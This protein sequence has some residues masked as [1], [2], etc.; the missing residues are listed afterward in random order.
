MSIQSMQSKTWST[1]TMGDSGGSVPKPYTNRTKP[2][3][4]FV[5]DP[6]STEE[7]PA[8]PTAAVVSPRAD[9][10]SVSSVSTVTKS[11]FEAFQTKLLRF[12]ERDPSLWFTWFQS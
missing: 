9:T 6:E 10:A 2:T 8:L 12:K 4:Q 1:I 3:I 5:F 7:F 11:D